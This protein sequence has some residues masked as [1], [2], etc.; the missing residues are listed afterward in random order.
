MFIYLGPLPSTLVF[1]FMENDRF[2]GSFDKSVLRFQRH[3]LQRAELQFDA[4]PIIGHPLKMSGKNCNQMFMS[5]LQ[6]TNRFLNPFA[7]GSLTQECFEEHNF[8]VFTNLKNDGYKHGQ[9]T[10]K[11]NFENLLT[12][13]LLCIFIPIWDRKVTFDGYFNAQVSN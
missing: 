5:Y 8:F 7:T 2:D 3:G 10:L 13:K 4:Q 11:L 6:N 12:E 1:G 9:L